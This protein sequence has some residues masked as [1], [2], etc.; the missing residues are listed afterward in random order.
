ISPKVT[1]KNRSKPFNSCQFPVK[2]A[3]KRADFGQFLQISTAI[4]RPKTNCTSKHP[5]SHYQ[6]PTFLARKSIL[7]PKIPI[8]ISRTYALYPPNPAFACDTQIC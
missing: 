8:S 2:T 1:V 3:Q 5:H 6:E 4:F 7:P